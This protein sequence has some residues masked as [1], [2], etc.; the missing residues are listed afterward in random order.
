[1]LEFVAKWWCRAFHQKVM[2]PVRGQYRCAECLREWPVAWESKAVIESERQRLLQ[3]SGGPVRPY[4]E[5][6]VI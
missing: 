4:A 2:R 6:Q 1:M 3:D 5:S